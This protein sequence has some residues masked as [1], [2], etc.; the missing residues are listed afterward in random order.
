[1]LA[2]CEMPCSHDPTP[3]LLP[4]GISHTRSSLALRLEPLGFLGGRFD[5]ADIHEGL[6][7]EVI[8]LAFA[9]LVEAAQRIL[10]LGVVAGEAGEGF[11]NEEGLRQEALDLPGPRDDELV[12]FAQ[13]LD[14]QDRDDVLEATAPLA[15]PP[16]VMCWQ[17]RVVFTGVRSRNE[18]RFQLP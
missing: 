17:G 18:S 13:L 9:Q 3:S 7:G 1:M 12:L 14:P 16:Y 6:F 2:G 4:A 11:G 10:P 8:P 15:D 5:G